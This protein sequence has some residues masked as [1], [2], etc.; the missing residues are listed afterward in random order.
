MSISFLSASTAVIVGAGSGGTEVTSGGFKY[1][2]F[3]ASG[4]FTVSKKGLF[5]VLVIGGG[6]GGGGYVGAGGGAGGTTY[7]NVYF[8]TG[9]QNTHYHS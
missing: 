7:D 4:T 6:G 8:D 3:T 5:E 1:H 2:T 9:A